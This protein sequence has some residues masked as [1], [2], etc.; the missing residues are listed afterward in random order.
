MR[1]NIGNRDKGLRILLA[2]I[3]TT[4]FFTNMLQGAWAYIILAAGGI[5]LG[6]ALVNFC[7]LYAIFGIKTCRPR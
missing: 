1:K 5:L 2:V 6:T 3:A 4:L 7:P